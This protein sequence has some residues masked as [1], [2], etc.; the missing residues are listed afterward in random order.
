MSLEALFRPGKNIALKVP[1]DEFTA[2]VVFYR[3]IIGLEVID[4]HQEGSVVF[5]FGGKRLWI[6]NSPQFSQ[7]E[8]W[9]EVI[10]TDIKAAADCLKEKGVT[11][12]DSIEA[13]PEGFAG[14]WIKSPSGIIHLI[15]E[16]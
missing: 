4:D 7:A 12:Q 2:T 6:D 8:T 10:A 16:Q 14:F 5:E 13:L 15:S 11:R 1:P 3:D 9:L